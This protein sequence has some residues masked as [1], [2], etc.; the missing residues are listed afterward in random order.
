M[1]KKLFKSLTKRNNTPTRSPADGLSLRA[2]PTHVLSV[3]DKLAHAGYEAYL[4]GGCVRDLL[5]QCVP[6]DFDVA[7]S[8]TPQ[9]VRKLFR[10]SRLI[11]RRFVLVH[12]F[13][14]K[15]T[16]EVATFRGDPSNTPH[17]IMSKTGQIL[18]DNAY[19]SIEEDAMR[20]DFTINA[21]FYDPR[22][23]EI[24]DYT[25]GLGDI[26]KKTIRL[27]GTPEV[28]YREDPMRM[29]RALRFAAKLNFQIDKA[30]D[31]SMHH[32][33]PLLLSVPPARLFEETM[34]LF[35][36]GYAVPVMAL[37]RHYRFEQILFKFADNYDENDW[38]LILS[39]LANT[40]QRY[41]DHKKCSLSFIIALLCF[42]GYR[43]TLAALQQGK[44]LGYL[45]KEEAMDNVLRSA[46][47]TLQIPKRITCIVRGIWHLQYALVSAKPHQV[48]RLG[49]HPQ[50]RPALDLLQIRAE[51]NEPDLQPWLNWWKLHYG[52]APYHH[53]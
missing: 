3:V 40:D 53:E 37:L 36:H 18:Q 41:R 23:H 43:H 2:I 33:G 48:E 7:T 42:G 11:G 22:H 45:I 15:E 28:R 5:T 17:R 25:N 26:R 35:T 24:V 49:N 13:F 46:S 34:K 31:A 30:T 1:I 44:R 14:G 6:K 8:A 21:L 10:N 27:I 32:M 52:N 50:F 29:L 9:E 19:G 20:R 4:V 12:V 47:Q 16:V 38:A 51:L 39:G